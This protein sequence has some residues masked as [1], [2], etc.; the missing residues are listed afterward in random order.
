MEKSIKKQSLVLGA[1]LLTLALFFTSF[2]SLSFAEEDVTSNIQFINSR[3]YYDRGT[4]QSYLD[5]QI[6]NISPTVILNAPILVV[7]ESIVPTA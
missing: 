1:V 7:I 3:L 6:K 4:K 5:V 2:S